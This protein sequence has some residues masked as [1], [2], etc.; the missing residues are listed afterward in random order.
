MNEHVTSTTNRGIKDIHRLNE[1]KYRDETGL[2]YVEGIRPI[3][4]AYAQK[5]D[6]TRIVYCPEILRSQ[7]ALDFIHQFSAK[8]ENLILQVSEIVFSFIAHKE[9]P[10]GLAAVIR[11]RW[12]GLV[13]IENSDSGIWIGLDSVQD[14]GNLGSILRTLD[15]VGGKGLILL[16][17]C[18]DVYHPTAVRAS[19][20]AVFTQKIIKVESEEFIAWKKKTRIPCFGSVCERADD[21]QLILYPDRII[22]LMGSEQ[23][24]LNKSLIDVSDQ[25]INLPMRGHVDSLNLSNAASIILY[26]VYNQSRKKG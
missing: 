5:A 4:E 26:E 7:V 24:G 8:K 21:Y 2:F 22:I 16:D 14:P 23:K 11:Q 6:I 3:L 19:M 18:T 25:L 13:E 12:D 15:A 10:Q 20:G 1:K 17:Q 9:G